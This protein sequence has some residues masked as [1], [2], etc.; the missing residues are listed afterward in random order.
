MKCVY[1]MN[2]QMITICYFYAYVA[3]HEHINTLCKNARRFR[4]PQRLDCEALLCARAVCTK[5]S[6]A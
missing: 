2:Y 4:N 3:M 6:T 5:R 1:K